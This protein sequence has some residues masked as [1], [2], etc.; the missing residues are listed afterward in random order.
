MRSL[1][2]GEL[3][4]REEGYVADRALVVGRTPVT[5]LGRAGDERVAES[6]NG[7]TWT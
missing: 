1:L 2:I 4:G 3:E 5:V 7:G 6:A